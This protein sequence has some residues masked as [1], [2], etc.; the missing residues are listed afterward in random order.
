MSD[1]G[2][3]SGRSADRCAGDPAASPAPPAT[4][5]LLKALGMA[6]ITVTTYVSAQH[7]GVLSAYVVVGAALVTISTYGRLLWWRGQ[8]TPTLL[9]RLPLPP[10]FPGS[11]RGTT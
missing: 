2:G 10:A 8:T 6:A 3:H 4:A 7:A 11:A 9:V 5:G 1:A